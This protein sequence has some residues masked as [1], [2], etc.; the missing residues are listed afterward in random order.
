[1]GP[2]RQHRATGIRIPNGRGSLLPARWIGKTEPVFVGDSSESITT[3][4]MKQA[5]RQDV[6]QK[7]DKLIEKGLKSLFTGA[8]GAVR[9]ELRIF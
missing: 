2:S 9:P 7:A 3:E 8:S 6:E 5:L 1:M 4:G